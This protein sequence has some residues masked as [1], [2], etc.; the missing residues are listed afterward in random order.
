MGPFDRSPNPADTTPITP[1][2]GAFAADQQPSPKVSE[3]ARN[4][5][6]IEKDAAVAR[7]ALEAAVTKQ[8]EAQRTLASLQ[9]QVDDAADNLV[10]ADGQHGA[11]ANAIAT[12]REGML[13]SWAHHHMDGSAGAMPDYRDIVAYTEAVDDFPRVRAHLA[14]EL[15]TAQEALRKFT[16]ENF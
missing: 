14:K 11:F 9:R 13:N 16:K 1:L 2:R 8:K 12:M 3:L 7:Q 4:F 5:E 10:R 6:R 15:A